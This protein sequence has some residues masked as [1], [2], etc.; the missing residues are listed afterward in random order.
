MKAEANTWLLLTK[1]EQDRRST[2]ERTQLDGSM[3][4]TDDDNADGVIY[5]TPGEISS[6]LMQRDVELRQNEIV[7]R[8]L[9]ETA[10]MGIEMTLERFNYVA[11]K[12]T[13]QAKTVSEFDPDSTSRQKK[14]L[15]PQDAEHEDRL[16]RQ[17]WSLIRCGNTQEAQEVCR[18]CGQ[19]WRGA[20]LIGGEPYQHPLL[21][22]HIPMGNME[23]AAQG[24]PHR[25]A[26]K[27]AAYRLSQEKSIN[28]Y[29]RAIYA[30][31]SGNVDP[32]LDVGTS[33]EDHL[34]ANFKALYTSKLETKMKEESAKHLFS[35]NTSLA[36]FLPKFL[37]TEEGIIAELKT[38]PNITV[39]QEAADKYRVIQSHIIL[40]TLNNLF[41][42]IN[43]WIHSSSQRKG[44]LLRFAAHLVLFYYGQGLPSNSEH[45]P[46]LHACQN[47]LSARRIGKVEIEKTQEAR[48]VRH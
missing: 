35:V 28:S 23:D 3:M 26:W 45:T 16:F 19:Y 9:E 34:W 29:E 5:R 17:I 24:N 36:T 39:R 6:Q 32:M 37:K 43:Q 18:E 20:S 4:T 2:L 48:S 40:A 12:T 15:H 38:S 47:I 7:T 42:E 13:G 44:P 30:S 25:L 21:M 11:T 1:L 31:L 46:V 41:L 22:S 14:Q 10:E 33:W 27:F 8:W